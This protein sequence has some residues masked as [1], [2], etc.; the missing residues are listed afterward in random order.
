MTISTVCMGKRDVYYLCLFL[1][2]I[3][4]ILNDMVKAC[5]LDSCNVSSLSLTKL[6][7]IS[8]NTFQNSTTTKK[9]HQNN[10]ANV[11]KDNNNFF[12]AMDE[13][14]NRCISY[15]ENEDTRPKLERES[16]LADSEVKKF[17]CNL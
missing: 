1:L 9:N 10:L 17:N 16:C 5:L 11:I 4:P 2:E 13:F 15:L 7:S 8:A 6:F 14:S 12:G 3:K